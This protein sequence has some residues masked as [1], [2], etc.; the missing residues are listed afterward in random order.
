MKRKDQKK[1]G[2][3]RPEDVP[4]GAFIDACVACDRM[5]WGLVVHRYA[6][7]STHPRYT[8]TAGLTFD[9]LQ[10]IAKHG[11]GGGLGTWS[12]PPTMPD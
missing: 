10:K 11:G 12:H 1:D 3:V 5:G 2:A 6:H 4:G 8:M 7:V 9:E